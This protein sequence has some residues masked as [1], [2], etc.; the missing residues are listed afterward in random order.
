MHVYMLEEYVIGGELFS[1]L[2]RAGCFTND[3][4]LFYAGEILLAIEYMHSHNIIYRDLKPENLLLDGTGNVKITDFGFAKFVEDRTWTLCGTPEYVVLPKSHFHICISPILSH[5][6]VTLHSN[7]YKGTSPPKSFRVKGMAKLW[8]GG[9][10][11]FLS[12]RCWQGK[13]VDTSSSNLV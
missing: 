13:L 5:S 2:R 11:E 12:L 3:M 6:P 7:V 10:W 8:T 9:L 4:T 1:H